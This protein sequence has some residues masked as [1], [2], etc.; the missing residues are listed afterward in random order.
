[1][2]TGPCCGKE[3]LPQQLTLEE[4]QRAKNEKQITM[5]GNHLNADTRA[6]IAICSYAG[7]KLNFKDVNTF[8]KESVNYKDFIEL[9]PSGNIPLL[10]VKSKNSTTQIIGDSMSDD[11]IQHLV[12]QHD[13]VQESL[14]PPEQEEQYVEMKKWLKFVLRKATNELVT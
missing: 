7:V 4:K 11:I 14:Y 12:D 13:K 5:Y 9:Q 8:D 2:G 3:D 6:V 10:F 1:M